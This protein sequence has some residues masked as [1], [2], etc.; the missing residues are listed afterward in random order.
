MSFINGFFEPD[1]LTAVQGE[2]GEEGQGS[3][4]SHDPDLYAAFWF[5]P[6]HPPSLR[7]GGQVWAVQIISLT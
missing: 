1:P 7:Y 5:H 4:Y 2:M 6:D 3:G